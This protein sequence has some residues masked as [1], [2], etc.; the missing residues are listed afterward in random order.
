MPD[1]EDTP[2][3]VNGFLDK[4]KWGELRGYNDCVE[5]K[6]Q[7]NDVE[8]W[9]EPVSNIRE[10]KYLETIECPPAERASTS[11][12]TK[13]DLQT[14]LAEIESE[15][16]TLGWDGYGAKPITPEAISEIR[17]LLKLLPAY[18]PAPYIVPAPTGA[19]TLE[20]R[21]KK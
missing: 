16:Q 4:D 14:A 11:E 10:D 17:K 15:C 12:K 2:K 8:N 1:L 13:E 20:W 18:A 3:C 5:D 6:I 7:K 19:I 9:N 21:K